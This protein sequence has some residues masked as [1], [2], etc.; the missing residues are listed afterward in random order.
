[1]EVAE[2][3]Q[4]TYYESVRNTIWF[5]PRFYF[6]ITF[7]RYHLYLESRAI[8]SCTT[9]LQILVWSLGYRFF[10]FISF[11]F[12]FCFVFLLTRIFCI[13]FFFFLIFVSIPV[14][15]WNVFFH[16]PRWIDTF[17]LKLFIKHRRYASTVFVFA[18]P[19]RRCTIAVC[20][21]S[22][23]RLDSISVFH[24]EV[25]R[26]ANEY[27][28]RHWLVCRIYLVAQQEKNQNLWNFLFFTFTTN[29]SCITTK[30][31]S[32]FRVIVT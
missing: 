4:W 26:I 31:N 5:E 18:L 23:R 11:Y 12:F 20:R 25:N 15:F 21:V 6:A 16:F 19:R 9:F 27:L 29:S 8:P 1:M 10:S 22:K 7:S 14:G 30:P 2:Y 13:F 32:C 24:F 17:E 3:V 28:P